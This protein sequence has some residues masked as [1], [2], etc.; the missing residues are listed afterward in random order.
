MP[1]GSSPLRSPGMA[2]RYRWLSPAPRW[3]RTVGPHALPCIHN[4]LHRPG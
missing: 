2:R 3:V 4:L 1:G